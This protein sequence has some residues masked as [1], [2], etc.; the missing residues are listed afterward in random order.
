MDQD[1]TRRS[2]RNVLAVAVAAAAAAVVGKAAKPEAAAAAN[3]QPVLLGTANDASATTQV[4]T[5]AG[6][7]LVGKVNNVDSAGLL[8]MNSASAVS[9]PVEV[10]S[11]VYGIADGGA[12]VL[13]ESDNVGVVGIGG[14][15]V[16]G[17]GAV[18]VAGDVATGGTGVYGFVGDGLAPDPTPN[19]AVEARAETSGLMALNVVGRASFSRSGRV[20][21]A[22]GRSSVTI[23]MSRI[24][25]S[26]LI[27]AVPQTYQAGV[28]L[29]A[30]TPLTNAFVIRLNKAVTSNFTVA[31]LVLN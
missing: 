5:T 19:V 7:G 11:G 16:Y 18:G 25:T 23:N 17:G 3:G 26:S 8:G 9:Q 20:V 31:F 6:Y 29:V 22:A 14:W 10:N 21:V 12:G 28:W 4:A 2:R 1:N 24:S 15:G 13:G 30:A 27:I